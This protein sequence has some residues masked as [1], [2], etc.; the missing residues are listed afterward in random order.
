MFVLKRLNFLLT[1]H[2]K[3]IRRCHMF[4]FQFTLLTNHFSYLI[5]NL[6]NQEENLLVCLQIFWLRSVKLTKIQFSI[7]LATFIKNAEYQ[8]LTE[9]WQPSCH[10]PSN[11]RQAQ[12]EIPVQGW[13]DRRW[14]DLLLST[15]CWRKYL[16]YPIILN[17]NCRSEDE[18]DPE[19]KPTKLFRVSR[20]KHLKG[21]PHWERQILREFGLFGVSW[22]CATGS[23]KLD[24]KRSRKI[25]FKTDISRFM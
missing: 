10:V 21:N 13:Q 17:L 5:P 25:R 12:Q 20:I 18:V 1:L 23:L 11:V 22:N 2:F 14:K 7:F 9:S 24:E 4:Q 3:W 8:K 16:K 6:F 19:I 15:V